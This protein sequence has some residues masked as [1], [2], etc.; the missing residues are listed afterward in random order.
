LAKC[1]NP[2]CRNGLTPGIVIAGKGNA[3]LPVLGQTMRWGWVHCLACNPNEE[4]RRRGVN[5]KHVSR[6]AAEIAQ[7]AELANS[8][9]SYKA[10]PQKLGGIKKAN[11]DS[12][13]TAHHDGVPNDQLTKLLEQ[14]GKLMNN[15]R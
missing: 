10:L 14:V 12:G 11:E 4:E 2:E 6:S 15:I 3:K 8:K 9:A 5:Y 13:P 7:R 1:R